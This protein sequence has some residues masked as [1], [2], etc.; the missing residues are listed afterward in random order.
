MSTI[1]YKIDVTYDDAA[2]VEA[3]EEYLRDLL[4]ELYNDGEIDNIAVTKDGY[5]TGQDGDI[6]ELVDVLDRLTSDGVQ[7]AIDSVAELE[8]LGDDDDG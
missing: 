8:T 4:Q 3:C 5:A 2:N 1:T 7:I 6:E